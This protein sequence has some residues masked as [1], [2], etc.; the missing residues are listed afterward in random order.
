MADEV[1]TQ[2]TEAQVEQPVEQQAT[3][4]NNTEQVQA[5]EAQA[6]ENTQE[7]NGDATLLDEE[8]E[9]PQQDAQSQSE[10]SADPEDQ[11]P[12]N[13][14]YQIFNAN[15]EEL[16]AEE[17]E[18]FRNAFKEAHL[19]TR[20]AKL[21]KGAYDKLVG[22]F[23]QKT[24]QQLSKASAEWLSDVKADKELGGSNFTNTVVNVKKAIA[25]YGDDS[26]TALLRE[27]KLANNPTVVRFLNNIGK[28]LAEDRVI[29]GERN[30]FSADKVAEAKRLYPH[31]PELWGGK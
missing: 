19:T 15:G 31:S 22:D 29:V 9:Q 3:Q 12:A 4:E 8:I 28:T 14:E 5:T 11:E 21:L 10:T 16:S 2:A 26:F 6:T 24:A 1:Q 20:Q 17:A 30:G 18:P 27:S 13:G 7:S 23:A 25:T